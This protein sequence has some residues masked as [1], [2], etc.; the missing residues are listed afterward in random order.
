[1]RIGRTLAAFV[2][3]IRI[4]FAGAPLRLKLKE[5]NPLVVV[6]TLAATTAAT[7]R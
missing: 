4:L 3:D 1:M 2:E 7:Q 6:D 5:E